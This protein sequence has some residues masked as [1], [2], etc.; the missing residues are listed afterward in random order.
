MT[1]R[2]YAPGAA[3]GAEVQKDGD[4]WTLAL[5]RDLRHAPEKVWQA[6]VDPA[7]LHQWAPFDADG[8]LD[9]AGAK[10]TLSTVGAGQNSVTTIRRADA[11]H[12]LEYDWNGALMRWELKPHGAGTRLMLWHAID[13]RYIAMGA[14]G[15]HICLDVLDHLVAGQ[16]LGR[17]VGGEAM[18]HEWPRLNKEYAAQFG[19]EPISP[20]GALR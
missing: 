9:T 12:A 10:V 14:A 17:I 3:F 1:D 4:T 16:P 8:R 5:V 13:R 7:Q 18:K 20:Y 19:V 11:P 2:N 6:L 15:W